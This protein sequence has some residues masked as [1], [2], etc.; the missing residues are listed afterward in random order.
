MKKLKA[1]LLSSWL[2]WYYIIFSCYNCLATEKIISNWISVESEHLIMYYLH[3]AWGY[4]TLQHGSTEGGGRGEANSS[5][6]KY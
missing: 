4:Y 1:N 5:V 3:T 2:K 6:T